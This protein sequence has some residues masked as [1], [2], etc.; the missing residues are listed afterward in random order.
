MT[1]KTKSIIL[2][3][4]RGAVAGAIGPMLLLIPSNV[5]DITNIKQWLAS[6]GIAAFV[7]GIGGTLQAID[8]ALR[9]GD[10]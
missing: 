4:V 9:M 2:R 7:G 5:A 3:F 8:K 6:L 10:K 1:D